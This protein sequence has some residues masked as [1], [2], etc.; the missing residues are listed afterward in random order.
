LDIH[1]EFEDDAFFNKINDELHELLPNNQINFR[2]TAMPHVTLYLTEF[3]NYSVIQVVNVYAPL[4]IIA[5]STST[6]ST[7][8]LK[9]TLKFL[10]LSF[11]FST[12]WLVQKQKQA[13]PIHLTSI[14]I[15]G[16][17]AMWD[18]EVTEC[19][20]ELSNNV[21]E[22]LHADIVPNQ[23]IP[24]WVLALPE[25]MRS[26]KINMIKQYGSPNV[27]SQFQAHVTLAWD[28]KEP[29]QSAFQ[30]LDLQPRIMP[31]KLVGIGAVGPYGTVIRG[32]NLG[33]FP[34]P[35]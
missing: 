19:L 7:L 2:T 12:R 33:T 4:N 9:L 32:R 23:P 27:F 21:V 34:L 10:E 25:P 1:I 22:L 8:D 14:T 13:C 29:M 31:A 30:K 17:Y 18:V 26:E 6:H 3:R 5:L 24:D 11:V 20:Q 35:Q 15:Q 28:N 16:S